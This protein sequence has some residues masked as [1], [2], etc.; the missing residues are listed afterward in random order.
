M[1]VRVILTDDQATEQTEPT[2]QLERT[3]LQA[4]IDQRQTLFQRIQVE[5]RCFRTHSRTRTA[6]VVLLQAL[7][8]VLNHI[9]FPLVLRVQTQRY[10]NLETKEK[11]TFFK[12]DLML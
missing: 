9:L 3:E 7:L 12:S 5:I 11:T 2:E 1:R 6:L 4:T 10:Y 8:Q